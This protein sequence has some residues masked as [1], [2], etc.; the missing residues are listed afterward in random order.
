MY[1]EISTAIASL[2]ERVWTS[3]RH[4]VVVVGDNHAIGLGSY[5]DKYWGMTLRDRIRTAVEVVLS[6]QWGQS[7]FVVDRGGG[8]IPLMDVTGEMISR[9]EKEVG[10]IVVEPTK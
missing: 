3:D 2:S 4:H 1:E 5:T 7:M 8:V 9:W 10:E 6:D